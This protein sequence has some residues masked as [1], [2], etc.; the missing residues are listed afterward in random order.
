MR[1]MSSGT[2]RHCAGNRGGLGLRSARRHQWF[3][4]VTNVMGSVLNVGL[5]AILDLGSDV[6]KGWEVSSPISSAR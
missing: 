5:L 1:D 3:H 6:A 2:R 4:L